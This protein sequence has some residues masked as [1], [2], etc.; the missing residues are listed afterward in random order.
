M[1]DCSYRPGSESRAPLGRLGLFIMALT[2]TVLTAGCAGL[3]QGKSTTAT[4]QTVSCERDVQPEAQ[5]HLDL[6]DRLTTADKP[7]AALAQLQAESLASLRHWLRKGKLLASTGRMV[8]AETLFR[9]L[10]ARCDS[11]EAR[12][13]LG[14]ILLKTGRIDEGLVA[15]QRARS[16]QPA[17]ANIRNDYGYG[18]LLSGA[19]E[20][21]AFE[22]RTALELAD[23]QGPVRQ[24]LAAAYLLTDDHQG[25]Q[26][27]KTQYGFGVDELAHARRLA[28]QLRRQP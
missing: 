13:G 15:L 11:G 24:N 25:L 23:G 14:M 8:E 20:H 1:P 18:L 17:L 21:A 22:L 12:H 7:Y 6:V 27:L 5:V 19:Y 2:L 10:V 3:P 4:S 28:Q 26:L 16:Q 9:D